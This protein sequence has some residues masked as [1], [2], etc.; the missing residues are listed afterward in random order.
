MLFLLKLLIFFLHNFI[1]FVSHHRMNLLIVLKKANDLWRKV[2]V[3]LSP[4]IDGYFFYFIVEMGQTRS[5]QVFKHQ[6]QFFIQ[7]ENLEEIGCDEHQFFELNLLNFLNFY[8]F[9]LII[10]RIFLSQF[11][12]KAFNQL[13]QIGRTNLKQVKGVFEREIWYLFI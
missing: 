3:K 9:E 5:D 10:S 6:N 11:I 1:E 13:N 7:R 2:A 12:Q 4:N 8:V